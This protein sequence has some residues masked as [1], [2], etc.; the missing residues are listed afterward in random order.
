MANRIRLFTKRFLFYTN[1]LVAVV[2]LLACIAPYLS[3]D[4]WWV[5]SILG[6]TLIHEFH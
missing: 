6:L 4:R 1:I 5:I 2:F 3:P